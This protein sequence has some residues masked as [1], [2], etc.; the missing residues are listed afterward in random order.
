MP[1]DA[2]PVEQ[3]L[4]AEVATNETGEFKVA[5]VTG[6]VTVTVANAGDARNATSGS[7]QGNA[8]ITP[9]IHRWLG[10]NTLWQSRRLY[11]WW[12]L[13]GPERSPQPTLV[14]LSAAWVCIRARLQSC[15]NCN[16]KLP[17]FSPCGK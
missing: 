14:L 15:R 8:F 12:P 11:G 9:P 10:V 1:V 3:V 2:T 16:Q 5:P 7:K 6:D 13:K 4:V 17:G